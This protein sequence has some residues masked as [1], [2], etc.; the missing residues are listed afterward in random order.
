MRLVMTNLTY[1]EVKP[2]LHDLVDGLFYRVPTGVG[3]T[4]FVRCSREEFREVLEQGSRW[5]LKRGFAWPEDLEMTEEGGCF[6]GANASKVSQKA[7]ERG[8]DQ[9]GTLGS[10]NHYCEIQVAK[11]ENIFDQEV[12]RTLG[13]TIPNQVVIMFHC[14]SRGFGH[15]VATDYLQLFLGVMERKYGIKVYDRELACAPFRSQEGQDYFAAMKCAVNMAFANRQVI[16]HRIREVFSDQF[17]KSP[18]ELGMNMIYDVAHNTAKLEKHTIDGKKREVLVHRK[19]STRAF[20]PG[21]EG[22]PQQYA[23]TGQ[24]VIIGGSMETGSYLLVGV[25]SGKEAFYTTAHGSGRTMSRHQAKKLFRGK[26]L[27]QDMEYRG[28]YVQTAS[29]GGLAEEAGA[30][31]KDIDDVVEAT[32]L[33]GLSRRVVKLVPIGNIKG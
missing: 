26:K 11:P 28:I 7:I 5:C 8:F 6:A 9:I 3:C 4:G 13:F 31:Y 20:G 16:L 32:E 25:E 22:L 27:Q 33:A 12:A 24:P 1:E 21:M 30:A 14:G 2:R 18:E 17:H 29:F 19:G 23:Q 10:G 15:Q